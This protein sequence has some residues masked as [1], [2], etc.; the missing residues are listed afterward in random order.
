MDLKTQLIR[1]GN[2]NP[3]LRKDLKPVIAHLDRQAGTPVDDLGEMPSVFKSI[4]DDMYQAYR[5][6]SEAEDEKPYYMGLR[7]LDTA[8]ADLN[9]EMRKLKRLIDRMR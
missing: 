5:M 3:E 8:Y 9:H 2:A 4:A 6:V 7:R 1:L